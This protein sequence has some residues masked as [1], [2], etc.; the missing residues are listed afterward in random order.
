MLQMLQMLQ[1]LRMLQMQRMLDATDA[2][3]PVD[4]E[5]G[6]GDD[7]NASCAATEDCTGEANYCVDNPSDS[8][9]IPYCSQECDV[10]A[11]CVAAGA[12]EGW[13]CNGVNLGFG[14][15]T[16]WCGPQWEI[17]TGGGVIIECE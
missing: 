1:T 10:T 8:E 7:W 6:T 16:A 4:E 12:P 13:T 9:D 17:G 15:F 14:C 2:T 3:D 5:P 11:D